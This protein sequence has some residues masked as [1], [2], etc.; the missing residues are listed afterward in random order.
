MSNYSTVPWGFSLRYALC[1][2]KKHS[3]SYSPFSLP[4]SGEAVP[5]QSASLTAPPIKWEEPFGGRRY[6][7]L[8]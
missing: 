3:I 4:H 5:P 8:K 7:S 6:E 1:N 2:D